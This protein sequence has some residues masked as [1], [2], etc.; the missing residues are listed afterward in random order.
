MA[1]GRHPLRPRGAPALLL[2]LLVLAGLA[3]PPA[4]AAPQDEGGPRDVVVIGAPGLSW[5]D[6]TEEG[7]PAITSFA[8]G[9]ALANLNVR[10]TYFTSCPSDG[11]LGLSAGTRAAEPRD[12]T[13]AQ[14]R[15]DPRALP[16]CSALPQVDS[17]S[18]LTTVEMDPQYWADLSQRISQQGFDAQIGTLGETA[19]EAGVCVSGSGPGSVLA[20]VDHAGG[21]WSGRAGI[22]EPCPITLVGAPA[23]TVPDGVR[24]QQVAA[25]DRTVA[26][27]VASVDGDTVVILAGLSDDGGKPGLRVLAMHGADVEPGWLHS[28]STTRDEMAQ[29]ADVTHTTLALAGLT[30]PDRVTGR[31]LVPVPDDGAYGDRRAS[32]VDDD[33]QLRAADE[34]IPPFFRGFGLGLAGLLVIAGL[35]GALGPRS[36]RPV[37]RRAV[38]VVALAAMAVPA[39]TYLLTLTRWFDTPSAMGGFVLRLAVIDLALLALVLVVVLLVQRRWPGDEGA[40]GG[41]RRS[42]LVAVGTV[43]GVT[44]GLLAVDLLLGGRMTMLSVLG[45]LPLDG[46]RFHG[47]GNVPFAI[48]VAAAFFLMAALASPFV[49][50]GRRRTAALVVAVVGGATFVVDAWLGADG[51]GALALIPSVG[52]L[53]LAVAGVR[54]GWGKVLTIGVATVVGFLAMAGLDWL[55]PEESRTHLGRFFGSLLAGDAWGILVRKLE[56]NV[57]LLLGPERTALLVP[58]VLVAVIWVLARPDSA[59]GQRIQPIL[60]AYPALRVGLIGLVV[61]LTVGFLLNDSGTAIP[62]AAALVLGPALVVLWI[63]SARQGARS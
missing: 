4:S 60:A 53:V 58:V 2:A 41:P 44:W 55:R 33:A 56:T 13:R 23:I 24:A 42:A 27:V 39:S 47:F 61:A 63:G 16:T 26:D 20:V 50:A 31:M 54:L 21:G 25:V 38:G 22:N 32:L 59:A 49:A 1:S 18:D 62:A 37:V 51:G 34:V 40:S 46:G 12:V 28:D 43:A 14:L 17:S 36:R 7:A 5:S 48:F 30:P 15:A 35:G 57:D 6:V 11:W 3:V 8:K 9:A 29:V 10:S 52:Y 45:L 19:E